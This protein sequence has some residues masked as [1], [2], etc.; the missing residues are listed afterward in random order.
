MVP[1]VD[2]P[3][4]V[5]APNVTLT[6]ARI[7]RAVLANEELVILFSRSRYGIEKRTDVVACGSALE[8]AQFHAFGSS[9]GSGLTV[10]DQIC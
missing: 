1:N 8:H 7:V 5:V 3:R 10:I 6:I 4:A 9:T 2:W